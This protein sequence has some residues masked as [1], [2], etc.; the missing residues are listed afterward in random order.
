MILLHIS[1]AHAV[2]TPGEERKKTTGQ[3]V[4]MLLLRTHH[5]KKT[6]SLIIK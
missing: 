2:L 4:K 3:D 5:I 6:F 1:V